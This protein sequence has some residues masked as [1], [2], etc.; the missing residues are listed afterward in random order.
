MN[1]KICSHCKVKK[2]LDDFFNNAAKPDGKAHLC[3]ICQRA[4]RDKH[5]RKNPAYYKDKAK[6]F[7]ANSR[8]IQK[9]M[10]MAATCADCGASYPNEP[11]LMEFDHLPEHE[12]LGNISKFAA[13]GQS[14][15]MRSE[16]LKCEIVCLICHKRRT[17]KR[18]GWSSG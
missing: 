14:K 7:S 8:A 5:Y 18:G 16:M 4:Y 15:K 3:K 9:R 10:K 2:P 6:A 17:A 1:T 12:K 11:W 13:C